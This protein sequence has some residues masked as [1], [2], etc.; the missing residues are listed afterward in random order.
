MT[1]YLA[2][3]RR[4]LRLFALRGPDAAAVLFF[5]ITVISLFPFSMAGEPGLLLKA[6][7]G[8]LWVGAVLSGL[9]SLESIH[10][11]DYED[12]TLDLLLMSPVPSYGI[13]AAKMLSH[14]LLSG[15]PLALASIPA[16]IMLGLPPEKTLPLAGTLALGTIYMS[17]LGGASA[18]LTFG[19]RRSGLLLAVLILPLFIPMLIL[20]MLAAEAGLADLPYKA[21]VLLQL[22]LVVA[23][24]PVAPAVAA[25]FFNM[26]LRSP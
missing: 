19:A 14:W 16:G 11:R 23:A 18:A 24:L 1:R 6:A 13:A 2:L 5:F 17:L 9:L 15:L 22:A 20:G 12:G 10:L 3:I 7:P 21:Y 25:G 26:H 8:I 4:D